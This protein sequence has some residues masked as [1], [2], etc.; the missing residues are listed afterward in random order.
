MSRVDEW[1]Y[2]REW[3]EEQNI[4]KV[5]RNYLDTNNYHII[6]YNENKRARGYDIIAEKDGRKLIVEVK[7]FPSDKYVRGPKKGQKKPT[8]PNLQAK[9]WF[10]E[11]LLSLI[12]AKSENPEISIS[13]G[14]P[15]IAKYK[16]LLSKIEYF[17]QKFDLKCYLVDSNQIVE[18]I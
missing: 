15:N 2:E 13:L 6:K 16:E 17:R 9:H 4:S 14:L 11:A 8:S 12:I 7:G 1:S 18:I 3:F 5:I 10:S